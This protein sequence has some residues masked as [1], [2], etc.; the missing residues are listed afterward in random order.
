[1]CFLKHHKNM[2]DTQKKNLISKYW[3][4]L[5]RTLTNY[6][7]WIMNFKILSTWLSPEPKKKSFRNPLILS[8]K[9]FSSC[10]TTF[11]KLIWASKSIMLAVTS[12]H[13]SSSPGVE[14]N[15]SNVICFELIRSRQDT[16]ILVRWQKVSVWTLETYQLS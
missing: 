15:Q 10:L 14:S 7:I 12:S 6:H 5:N 16:L 1:M 2:C 3:I 8:L 9:G 4:K 13:S 11:L